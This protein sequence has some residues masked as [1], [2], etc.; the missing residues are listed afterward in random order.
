MDKILIYASFQLFNFLLSNCQHFNQWDF[1]DF[2]RFTGEI[3]NH[4]SRISEFHFPESLLRYFQLHCVT[5]SRISDL[6]YVIFF[7][8]ISM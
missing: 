8:V 7:F 2:S 4:G 1:I 3:A 6:R 5:F